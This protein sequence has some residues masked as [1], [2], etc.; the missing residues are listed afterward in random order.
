MP[1]GIC[2][3][4]SETPSRI[5]CFISCYFGS[6]L[7]LVILSRLI[8]TSKIIHPTFPTNAKPFYWLLL[9]Y[10]WNYQVIPIQYQVNANTKCNKSI[11]YKFAGHYFYKSCKHINLFQL[12]TLFVRTTILVLSPGWILFINWL[13]ILL[14]II[15]VHFWNS[16]VKLRIITSISFS[17]IVFIIGKCWR[18][19]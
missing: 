5:L 19:Y 18:F 3:F 2:N 14:H 6:L 11:L 13:N 10:W 9:I 17:N 16:F 7:L 12:L 1:L 4:P 8:A 15:F